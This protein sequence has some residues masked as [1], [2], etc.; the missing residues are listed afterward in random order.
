MSKITDTLTK[1]LSA[2]PINIEG[3]IEELG[4][5]LVRKAHLDPEIS[6]QI[7]SLPDGKYQISANA[8][9]SYFRRRFTMAHELSHFLLHRD[10]I[11]D[12]VDDTPAYRSTDAG[13][14][15]NQKILPR[16]E[17]EANKLAA[18]ILMPADLVRESFERRLGNV[19][20][21]AADFQVSKEAMA[22][23]IKGLGL[24]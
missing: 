5:S 15:Y 1:F 14:F 18:R 24:K 22:Y 6:G 2:S 8:N 23:R 17:T 4:L 3:L 19:T 13:K 9:D 20:A 7:E 10:L 21:M 11:G 12:G 16:H